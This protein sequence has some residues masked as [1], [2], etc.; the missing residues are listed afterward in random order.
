MASGASR[1][2]SAGRVQ[3]DHDR[4][5]RGGSRGADHA[6]GCGTTSSRLCGHGS[7][8]SATARVPRWRSTAG[9]RQMRCPMYRGFPGEPEGHVQPA[10][11]GWMMLGPSAVAY[12]GAPVPPALTIEEI[13][14]AVQVFVDAAR[15]S[16]RAGSTSLRFTPPMAICCTSSSR[17]CRSCAPTG[18]GVISPGG[19][20]CCSRWSTRSARR[21]RSSVLAGHGVDLV[22]VSSGGLLPASIEV[23]PVYQVPFARSLP[24]GRSQD[25][26]GGMLVGPRQAEEILR[27]GDATW[28]TSP[29]RRCGSRTGRC[30]SRTSWA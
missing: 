20:G 21:G 10:D 2:T 9:P 3:A 30:E 19:P 15:R 29:R 22:D 27:R 28:S 13:G 18:T 17:R 25:R 5:S 12:P 23:A 6:A 8:S 16:D 7:S 1:R 24:G 4:V 26:R 14:G 11:E